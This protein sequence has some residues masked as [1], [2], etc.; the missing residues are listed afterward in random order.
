MEGCKESQYGHHVSQTDQ[1]KKTKRRAGRE[2]RE[3][4][5]TLRYL[6]KR[7]GSSKVPAIFVLKLVGCWLSVDT[8]VVEVVSLRNKS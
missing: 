1:Q 5:Q 6:A 8:V 3:V 2:L 7:I 4:E